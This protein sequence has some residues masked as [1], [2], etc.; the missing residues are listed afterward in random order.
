MVKLL[1]LHIHDG[2]VSL[3][4]VKQ[5]HLLVA[6]VASRLF[7]YQ[8]G[9]LLLFRL[10]MGLMDDTLNL[11]DTDYISGDEIMDQNSDGDE[12]EAEAVE[13]TLMSTAENHRKRG[14]KRRHSRCWK[15]FSIVGE[16]YP[17]GTNDMKIDNIKKKLKKLFDVY[18]K[19]TKKDVDVA[20]TSRSNVAK[21]TTLPGY[22]VFHAFFS[23]S[24]DGRGK[25]TLD[26]Y[27]DEPV[28]DM[29]SNLDLDV[30]TYWK[31]NSSRFKELSLMACDVLSIPI[32]TV[33]SESSFSIGSRVLNKYRSSLLPSNVRA[34][35]CA[36]NWL[37][38]FESIDSDE[39]ETVEFKP[40]EEVQEV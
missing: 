23:Q 17:D 13:D 35:I 4:M 37:R 18:K 11:E 25:S 27:L 39:V 8:M 15:H 1:L 40:L 26:K 30:L 9:L 31:N 38:G 33:A 7:R 12:A 20:G 22:G 28:L 32:T 24:A 29:G 10:M 5:V 21:K 3:F 36:R 6:S 14:G 34:L 16:K 2:F 19:N